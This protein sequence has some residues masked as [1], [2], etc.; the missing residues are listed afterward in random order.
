MIMHSIS[1]TSWQLQIQD[2]AD[3]TLDV[4]LKFEKDEVTVMYRNNNPR[5]VIQRT[6]LYNCELGLA[7]ENGVTQNR[8]TLYYDVIHEG[9]SRA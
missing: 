2:D 7:N 9:G 5:L 3:F 4:T 6:G 1:V 8:V